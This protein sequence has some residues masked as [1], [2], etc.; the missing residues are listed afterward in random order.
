MTK[1]GKMAGATALRRTV[2]TGIMACL[3]GVLATNVGATDFKTRSG[4]PSGKA[5]L[6]HNMAGVVDGMA[7]FRPV[8]VAYSIAAASGA[9]TRAVPG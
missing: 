9:A 3:L 1:P 7:F 5:M 6:S 8:L 4:G 2:R